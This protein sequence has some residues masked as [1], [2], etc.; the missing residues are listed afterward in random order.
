MNHLHYLLY[1]PAG[2]ISQFI[3][4]QKRKKL[5]LGD[6]HDFAPGTMAIGRLDEASEGAI[7]LTTDGWVSEW[8]RSRH[9]EKE[10]WVQV[11]GVI[12][13]EKIQALAE[14]VEINLRGNPYKTL[15]CEVSA[16][17][18]AE[19]EVL[20]AGLTIRSDRHG[21]TSWIRMVLREGKNRQVRRMTS[22]VGHPTLRL[23]RYRIGPYTIANW[24]SGQV[25]TVDVVN[26]LGITQK[27]SS[28]HQNATADSHT[29]G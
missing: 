4:I 8:V 12:S 25:E 24:K 20:P 28:T 13:Q 22:A 16:L 11:D 14:G 27:P 2:V 1:K 7:L 9:V 6:V 19:I 15:A 10:Y 26:D 17:T 29:L 3:R 18:A 23:V 5:L 21:P